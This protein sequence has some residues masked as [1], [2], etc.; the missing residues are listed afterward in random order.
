LSARLY[1]GEQELKSELMTARASRP[2]WLDCEKAR[3]KRQGPHTALDRLGPLDGTTNFFHGCR[4]GVSIALEHK[5]PNPLL[6]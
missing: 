5:R 6:R 1:S 3:A 2:L 4:I